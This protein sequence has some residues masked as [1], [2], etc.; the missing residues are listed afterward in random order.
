[1]SLIL[2]ALRSKP[3]DG[4]GEP[5]PKSEIQGVG[6]QTGVGNFLASKSL[7]LPKRVFFLAGGLGL[8]LVLA[9]V[10]WVTREPVLLPEAI[11][12]KN[13]AAS[14]AKE[15][16]DKVDP[17]GAAQRAYETKDLDGSLEQ[18]QALV[19]SGSESAEIFKNMGLL[20]FKKQL[21]SSAEKYFSKALEMDDRCAPC[22]NNFG[23]LKARLEE[24]T[25]AVKYFEKGMA[26]DP[27]LPILIL[28]SVCCMKRTV[29]SERRWRS[30]KSIARRLSIRLPKSLQ[31]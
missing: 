27:I 9:V 10:L 2:D 6:L 18:Y 25:V 8:S 30:T 4:K 24:T 3:T 12:P 20:Y 21:Y 23:L 17:L 1:M 28:I 19:E 15:T 5:P 13:F 22:F 26:I 7:L 31:P 16:P 29:T 11:Q 14:T